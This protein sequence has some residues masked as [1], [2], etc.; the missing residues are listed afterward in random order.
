M[1]TTATHAPT[2][3]DLLVAYTSLLPAVMFPIKAAPQ[4]LLAD[5]VDDDDLALDI[6]VDDGA[7]AAAALDE[8]EF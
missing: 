6:T 3:P 2:T 1:T 8:L 7:L 5:P 4:A